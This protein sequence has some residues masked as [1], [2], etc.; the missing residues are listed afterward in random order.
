MR[1]AN[2]TPGA[3]CNVASMIPLEAFIIVTIWQPELIL[4]HLSMPVNLNGGRSISAKLFPTHSAW[5]RN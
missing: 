2:E 1:Q 3:G 4:E 5:P